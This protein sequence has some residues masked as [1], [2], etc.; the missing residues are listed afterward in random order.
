MDFKYIFVCLLLTI[1][2]IDCV[3]AQT[4]IEQQQQHIIQ[5]QQQRQ[6]DLRDR[7]EQQQKQ[8][9]IITVPPVPET[10]KIVEGACFDITVIDLNGADHLPE[11][12]KQTLLTPFINQCIDLN[13][14]NELLEAI[15]NWYFEQGYI[16][17]RAYVA[18]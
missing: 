6:Q 14:I 7:I 3:V 9:Q 5:Q 11:S 8:H 17:S 18:A 16:T 13:K 4:S 10:G 2:P 1:V 12:V 15:S